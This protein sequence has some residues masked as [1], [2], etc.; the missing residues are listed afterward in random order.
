MSA[1]ADRLS[2]VVAVVTGGGS[3]FGA[4]TARTF[5]I[6]GASVVVGDIDLPAARMVAEAIV[7]NG[8]RAEAVEAD[9]SRR[10]A[11][12]RMVDT[13]EARF[14]CLNV[15]VNNAGYAHPIKPMAELD[16]DVFDR[17]FA[18]NV[19][20]LFWSVRETVPAMKRAG[21]GVFINVASMSVTRPRPNIGWYGASKAAVVTATKA[22]A[23]ELAPFKIRVCAIN[24]ATAETPIAAELLAD[25]AVRA[26]IIDT[27][28]LGRLCT[29][30]DIAQAAV[31]LASD[32]ASFLTGTCLDVDGGRA[33]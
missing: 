8:G 29:P 3:G 19:K 12:R 11:F 32:E 23:L 13:A 15:M 27:I 10:D 1:R 30:A 24:P 28:P 18:V 31:F 20:G 7:D 22:L 2:G 16:E 26:A 5:A 9:I 14:G 4:E 17:L 33:I 25:K 6:Q 21:G